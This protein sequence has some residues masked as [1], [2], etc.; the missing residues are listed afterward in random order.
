MDVLST[1]LAEDRLYHGV[2]QKL[3]IEMIDCFI[4]DF[5]HS[6]AARKK[7]TRPERSNTMG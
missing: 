4:R 5:L 1:Q 6:E 2:V 7:L 3:A